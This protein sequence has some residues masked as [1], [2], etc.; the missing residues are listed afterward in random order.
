MAFNLLT[1]PWLPLKRRSGV[2]EWV[3]PA[4]LTDRPLMWV[5]IY[6]TLSLLMST[7][8]GSQTRQSLAFP[9]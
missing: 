1:E 7:Y 4:H 2:T 5:E 3:S 8:M 9:V 6:G